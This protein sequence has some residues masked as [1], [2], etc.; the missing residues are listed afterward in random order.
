M[1]LSGQVYIGEADIIWVQEGYT[2][3]T[4][5]IY[6]YTSICIRIGLHKDNSNTQLKRKRDNFLEK[7]IDR[8]WTYRELQDYITKYVK[9][10]S[11]YNTHKY[12][13]I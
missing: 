4:N 8:R 6:N 10:L 13:Y 11:S 3:I 1:Q 12:M 2:R 7:N 9:L 5:I